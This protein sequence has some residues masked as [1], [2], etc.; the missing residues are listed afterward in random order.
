MKDY[1]H[2]KYKSSRP[3]VLCKKVFNKVAYFSKVENENSE[4]MKQATGDP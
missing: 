3:D 4:A 2:E 1:K